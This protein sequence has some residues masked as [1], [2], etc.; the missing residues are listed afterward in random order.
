M[1]RTLACPSTSRVRIARSSGGVCHLSPDNGPNTLQRMRLVAIAGR[2]TW[3]LALDY[4]DRSTALAPICGRIPDV[5]QFFER[6]AVLRH[7]PIWLFHGA[8]DPI[9]PI[10]NADQIVAALRPYQSPVRYTIYAD[11][12]HDAWTATYTNPE[13]YTWFLKQSR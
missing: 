3:Q 6:L 4:P 12:D 9:V 10:T 8:R 5:P 7:M 1:P 11:A 2:G 13:L